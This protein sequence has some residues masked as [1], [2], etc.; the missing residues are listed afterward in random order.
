MPDPRTRRPLSGRERLAL[1]EALL[2]LPLARLALRTWGF[3]RCYAAGLRLSRPSARFA[4]DAEAARQAAQSL[5]EIVTRAN[6]RYALR[7]ETCL[8][9]STA[10]WWMLRRRGLPAELRLGVRTTLGHFEAHAWV[11][12]GGRVLND[13]P[14]IARIYAPYDLTPAFERQ[15]L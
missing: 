10:L 13:V 8:P 4:Q 11:E 2:L 14:D 9:E 3:Q 15:S 12:H 1:L 5:A 6:T 7:R